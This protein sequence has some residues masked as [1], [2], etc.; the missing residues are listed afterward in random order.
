[1]RA[2][3]LGPLLSATSIGASMAACHSGLSASAFGSFVA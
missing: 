2:N 1:M 3:I